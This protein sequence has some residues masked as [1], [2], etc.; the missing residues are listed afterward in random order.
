MQRRHKGPELI[1]N[2]NQ[3]GT[4]F[5]GSHFFGTI[6]IGQTYLNTKMFKMMDIGLIVHRMCFIVHRIY[7]F[8]CTY[9]IWVLVCIGYMGFGVG[10]MQHL[11]KVFAAGRGRLF[12][13]CRRQQQLMALSQA[14]ECEQLAEHSIKQHN[15]WNQH[16]HQLA[17]S[18]RDAM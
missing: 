1:L 10:Y 7:V 6:P 11:V 8:W 16:Q 17:S 13:R 15:R 4:R 2:S 3:S 14:L 12:T 9:D 18:S 5:I